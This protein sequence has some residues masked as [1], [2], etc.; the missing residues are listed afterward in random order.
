MPGIL[1]VPTSALSAEKPSRRVLRV[2]W[3]TLGLNLLSAALK[4]AVGLFS[5][6]LTVLSDS[7]HS[8]LDAFNNVIGIFAI[9]YSWRPP[10][11]DHPYGHRKFEALASLG[12]GALMT[13]TS[14][15]IIKAVL[16][17]LFTPLPPTHV[18][19]IYIGAVA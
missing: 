13:L 3:I 12:V 15:E 1:N 9:S 18:S 4:L 6:N 16:Q 14:W 10:D 19:W 17:R 11:E 2:L 8:F 7:V 5:G